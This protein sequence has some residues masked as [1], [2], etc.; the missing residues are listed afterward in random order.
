MKFDILVEGFF[1]SLLKP[2]EKPYVVS[3]NGNVTWTRTKGNLKGA[4]EEVEGNFDCSRNDLQSL[5]GAPKKVR[6]SFYCS[7]NRLTTLKGSPYTV[8][9]DFYCYSNLI[10]SLEGAPEEVGGEFNCE[11]NPIKSLKGIPEATVYEL[12]QGFTEK[13]AHKE[14]ERRK[15]KKG[16]DTETIDTFGD[17]VGEL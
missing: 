15:F 16:L 12:P 7:Q 9:E 4:P 6:G 3:S 11:S 13:D 5:E 10:V 2:T 17:F 14:T 8:G 1:S